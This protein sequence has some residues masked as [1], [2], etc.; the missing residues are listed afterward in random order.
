MGWEELPAALGP[1]TALQP[2]LPWQG[3]L[4]CWGVTLLAHRWFLDLRGTPP[5]SWGGSEPSEPP[6]T[7]PPQ[8]ALPVETRA[9]PSHSKPLITFPKACIL[10]ILLS[11]HRIP[12]SCLSKA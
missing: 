2:L 12:L 5:V 11:L 6:T 7:E 8:P 9:S 3:P 10:T 1:S 4:P